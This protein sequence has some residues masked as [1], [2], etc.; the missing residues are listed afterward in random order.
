MVFQIVLAVA[1]F[2]GIVVSLSAVILLARSRLV[3]TG[4]V[5]MIVNNDRDFLQFS[6][7][8]SF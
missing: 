8:Y 7:S 5:Q 2:T 4:T 3:D 1:V 6:I